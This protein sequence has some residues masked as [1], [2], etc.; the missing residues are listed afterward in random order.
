MWAIEKPSVQAAMSDVEKF[1]K[2]GIIDDKD[3]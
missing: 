2:S 3:S 1:R